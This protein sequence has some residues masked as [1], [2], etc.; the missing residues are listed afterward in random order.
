MARDKGKPEVI[1]PAIVARLIAQISGQN[2]A[3]TYHAIDPDDVGGPG[4]FTMVISPASGTFD[5]AMFEGG[6]QSQLTAN[7]GCIVKIHSPVVLDEVKRDAIALNDAAKGLWFKAKQVIAALA[8]WSPGT[9]GSELTRNP[10]YPKAYAFTKDRT[11]GR[12]S[13]I[14]LHFGLDFDWDVS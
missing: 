6:G 14:E 3:N 9:A 13:A 1:Y 4:E 7:G 12:T 10:L 8:D 5:E 2:V 11:T